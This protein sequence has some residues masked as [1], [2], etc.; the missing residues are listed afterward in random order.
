MYL[1]T[2]IY[3]LSLIYTGLQRQSALK[4]ISLPT[5]N[6]KLKKKL[7]Y[8]VISIYPNICIHMYIYMQILK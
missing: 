8:K 4:T 5:T 2:A 3:H 1:N 7:M 6:T